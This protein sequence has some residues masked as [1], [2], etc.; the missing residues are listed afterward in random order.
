[1]GTSQILKR[2]N[3]IMLSSL[4]SLFGIGNTLIPHHCLLSNGTTPNPGWMYWKLEQ[5]R[6]E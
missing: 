6:T 4:L 3:A 5:T 1:M 2:M